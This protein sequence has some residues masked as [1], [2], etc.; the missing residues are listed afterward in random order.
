MEASDQ[1]EIVLEHFKILWVVC[2]MPGF[3]LLQNKTSFQKKYP[4][5]NNVLLKLKQ[6]MYKSRKNNVKKFIL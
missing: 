3:S 4:I 6:I 2:H 5:D 1:E